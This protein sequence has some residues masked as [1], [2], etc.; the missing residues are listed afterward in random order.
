MLGTD[1]ASLFNI[2][3]IHMVLIRCEE[4]TCDDSSDRRAGRPAAFS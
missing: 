4:S 1:L 2:L 3:D